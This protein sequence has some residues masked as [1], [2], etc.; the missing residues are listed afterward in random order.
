MQDLLIVP[1][2][3]PRP[4]CCDKYR[5]LFNKVEPSQAWQITP[6][7]PLETYFRQLLSRLAWSKLN[8]R[9]L[10]LSGAINCFVVVVE[11]NPSV[12]FQVRASCDDCN[13]C[14]LPS[15]MLCETPVEPKIQEDYVLQNVHLL[16][17]VASIPRR[18]NSR[19]SVNIY[20]LKLSNLILITN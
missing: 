13:V 1:R 15:F 4:E 2:T 10:F 20:A 18:Q 9:T 16:I 17:T 7:R 14:H 12:R 5:S 3:T 8:T 6:T 11:N 19:R